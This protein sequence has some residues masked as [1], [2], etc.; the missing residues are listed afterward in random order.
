MN[1]AALGVYEAVRKDGTQRNVVD[2]M[3]TRADLYDYL[4][5]HQFEQKLD[6]LFAKEK[7]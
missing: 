2:T 1:K 6:Q 5:Y 7:K 4:N 3:Q